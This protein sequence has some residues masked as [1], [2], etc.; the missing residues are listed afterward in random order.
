MV[1]VNDCLT[2][3]ITLVSGRLEG[4]G[5][6]DTNAK[7]VLA[8]QLLELGERLDVVRADSAPKCQGNISGPLGGHKAQRIGDVSGGG[9]AYHGD[10]RGGG[11]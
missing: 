8:D 5:R 11:T 9:M 1:E 2:G 6:R 10:E 7:H 4:A 3:G